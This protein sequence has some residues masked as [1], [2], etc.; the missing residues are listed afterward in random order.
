M[1]EWTATC[2]LRTAVDEAGATLASTTNCGVRIAAG[3]HRAYVTDFVRDARA[4]GCAAGVPPIH[5][6]FRLVR[7]PRSRRAWI[8]ATLD[9]LRAVR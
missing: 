9:R 8:A 7:E 4:G 3:R 5:L 2:Y 1:W 6:G